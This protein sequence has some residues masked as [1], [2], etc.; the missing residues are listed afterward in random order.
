MTPST[1]C[2]SGRGRRLWGAGG[3]LAALALVLGMQGCAVP[4]GGA[5]SAP[6]PAT[7]EPAA[8]GPP[9]SMLW[10]G[11]SFFYYNN[12]LHGHVGLLAASGGVRV[13]GVSSTISGSGLDWHDLPSL[14]R[15]GGLGRYSFVGDNE[16]RF[17]PPGRQFDSVVMMDCSQCPVHPQL[18]GAFH[19]TV[20]KN[21]TLLRERGIRPVLFMSWAYADKPDMTEALAAQYTAAGKANGA[22]VIPAGLAFARALALDPAVQLYAPDKRHPSL[23]GTYLAACTTYAALWGKSPVGLGYT[24]GLDPALVRTLQTAAWD[25][26][27]AQARR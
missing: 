17:N 19:D 4:G 6:A 21:A 12:S 3:L 10:V 8:S 26:V 14:L 11:N 15:P 23:A 13:R 2:T 18:Q 20:K 1:A 7:A 27:Q 5:S 16:I 22:Q 25:A 24:A 9:Q